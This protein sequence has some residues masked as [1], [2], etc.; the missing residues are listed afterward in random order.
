MTD[1]EVLQLPGEETPAATVRAF[2]VDDH[3]LVRQG[4]VAL[5]GRE[6]DIEIAGIASSAEEALQ[7]IPA[8]DP[9]VVITDWRL[10]GMDGLDLCRELAE[11]RSRARVVVLSAYLEEEAVFSAWLAGAA[12]YIVKDVEAGQLVR[13]V[14]AV[15]RGERMIDPKVAGRIVGWAS[16]VRSV[17]ND[18]LPAS[19]L[20]VLQLLSQGKSNDQIAAA[21]GLSENTVKKYLTRIYRRLNVTGRAEAVAEAMRRGLV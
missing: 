14:R 5:L 12:A 1:T 10:P 16:R 2:L 8:S 3:E 9:D 7:R 18:H 15:A 17:G 6:S 20:R 21:T 11:L 4:L 13:A 19:Q